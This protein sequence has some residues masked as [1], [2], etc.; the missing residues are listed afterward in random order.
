M[1]ANLRRWTVLNLIY[2]FASAGFAGQALMSMTPI[3]PLPTVVPNNG[4]TVTVIYD[5]ANIS[6]TASLTN[7]SMTP[8]SGV[9]Q[10][11]QTTGACNG[12]SSPSSCLLY[13]IFHG[14]QTSTINDGPILNT[15]SSR[16]RPSPTQILQMRTEAP[17]NEVNNSWI[18]VLIEQDPAPSAAGT[19]PNDLA[20]YVAKIKKLAPNLEQFHL[21]VTPLPVTPG[22]PTYQQ[23]ADTITAIRAA[24][25]GTPLIIGFHPDN[26]ST[27]ASCLGW[28]C[29]SVS[30]TVPPASWTAT[31]LTC[32]LNASI[33]TMN[34]ITA[35]LPTGKGFDTFSIEQG[36]VEPMA[37]CPLPPPPPTPPPACLQQIKACL[38]PQ[39]T[40]TQNGSACPPVNPESCLPGVT[41]ASPSVTYGNVLG[42]YGGSDIYGPTKL[43]FGYPQ[44]YNLGK[45]IAVDYDALISGGYFP[46]SS[47]ACHTAPYPPH[48]Y[49]VDVDT[50]GAYAPEIPCLI[51]G[52]PDA[53]NIYTNPSP[54]APNVTLA[55][56]YLAFIM[57]QYPPIQETVDTNG[58]TVYITLSGEP[59]FLGAPGWTLANIYQLNYNLGVNFLYLQKLYPS[60]FPAGIPPMQ[61]AIWNFGSIVNNMTL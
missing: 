27:E 47:T 54:A 17:N 18:K 12:T 20:T 1:S 13:L 53:A 51:V 60:L 7:F 46:S 56:N 35:L 39:G 28:G 15:G 10:I 50:P 33:Q 2:L 41:L 57:T 29:D 31:Q 34:M 19:P 5:V 22:S 58:A 6:S 49:V 37:T 23:Y 26:N 32:M 11:T 61:Y 42:S 16:T 30:C 38:C 25:P 59:N 43:D 14:D 36:Y 40:H 4:T 52:Q 8:I 44:Y 45:Q 21:R 48:L 9:E 3:T 55:S 24:Y